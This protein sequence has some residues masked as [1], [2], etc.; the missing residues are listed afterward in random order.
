MAPTEPLP[1]ASPV[2]DP[3]SPLRAGLWLA[4]VLIGAKAVLLG[5]P[6]SPPWLV[7]LARASF[8]DMLF[9]VA[10]GACGELTVRAL[11]RRPALVLWARAAMLAFLTL[12]AWYSVV[13]VGVFQYFDRPLSCALLRMVQNAASLRSSITERITLPLAVALVG[14]PAVFVTA[15]LWRCRRQRLPGWALALAGVW[16]AAGWWLHA[17]GPTDQ[18]AHRM[19]LNPHAELVRSIAVGLTGAGRLAFP[20]NFPPEN[21]LEF[22]SFGARGDGTAG[23]FE[24]PPGLARPRNVIVIVL[25]SVGTKYMSL[26]GTRARPGGRHAGRGDGRPRRGFPRSA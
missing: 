21:T 19:A 15:A 16:V 11:A 18:H 20:P 3:G 22:R 23:H 26:Y 7:Q 8:Q 24:A 5:V 1:A 12:C 25:E 10:V 9:A 14:V 6:Q 4:G 13:A 17:G 2:R